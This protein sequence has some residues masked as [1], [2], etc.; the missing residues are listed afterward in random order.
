MNLGE[1]QALPARELAAAIDGLG[2]AAGWEFGDVIRAAAANAPGSRPLP[3]AQKNRSQAFQNL[4]VGT[5]AE[6]VFRENHLSPLESEGFT[7][8]DLHERGEN[9]DYALLR[10]ESEL[11]IN[12]KVASTLFRKARE[13]VGLDP[14]DCIP[15]SAYKAIGAS[16]RVPTLVYVDLVDFSLRE[17]VDAFVE[18]LKGDLAIG[19]HLLS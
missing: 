9:R 10:D 2:V 4:V 18:E 17:R 13:T 8:A 11:P 1:V 16:E 3:E 15:I 5:I 14:E 6:R 7:V 19:W 12:V